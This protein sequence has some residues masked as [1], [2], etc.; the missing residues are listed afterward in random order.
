MALRFVDG[1]DHYAVADITRKWSTVNGGVSLEVGRNG[2]CL[3]TNGWIEY[4]SKSFD[5]QDTFII[6]FAFAVSV[7]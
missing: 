7:R 3:M 1:F 2:S 5:N 6:G 4:V